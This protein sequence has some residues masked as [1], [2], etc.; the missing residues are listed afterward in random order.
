MLEDVL[1]LKYSSPFMGDPTPTMNKHM[2][3]ACGGR[4]ILSVVTPS[5]LSVN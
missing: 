3:T 1:T 2:A 5:L 4:Y